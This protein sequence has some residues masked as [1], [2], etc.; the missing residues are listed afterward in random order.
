VPKD[1]APEIIKISDD[2]D[3]SEDE[4]SKDEDE[5]D[6]CVH[7]LFSGIASVSFQT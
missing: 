4:Q 3:A 1:V 2:S 7:H 5:F 6:A